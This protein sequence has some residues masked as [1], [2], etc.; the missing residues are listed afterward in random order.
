MSIKLIVG[1]GNPGSEYAST[2]HNAGA[3]F[4]EYLCRQFGTTLRPDKKFHGL[5][6]KISISGQDLHLLNPTTF[7]NRSGMAV[8]AL[9]NYL[10]INAD[11]VLVAHDEL[12]IPC[13]AVKVKLGGGH[14]GHNGLR[15]I[16]KALGG[17]KD[18]YRLRL[19]ID[20]PGSKEKVVGFVLG[21]L[22]KS[23]TQKL[24]ASFDEVDRALSMLVEGEI[25]KATQR[26]NSYKPE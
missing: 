7:M 21:Q 18:F 23:E 13:G 24:E 2:R 1:L 8:Q 5:Y 9:C 20:H 15:D 14:G 16:I 26:I 3:L 10:K 19:G 6:A 17:N 4:V 22:G 25:A 11:E 12:D